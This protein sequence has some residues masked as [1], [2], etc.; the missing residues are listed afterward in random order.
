MYINTLLFFSVVESQGQ[1]EGNLEHSKILSTLLLLSPVHT[2]FSNICTDVYIIK[3]EVTLSISRSMGSH[4]RC[5]VL[6]YSS[7]KIALNGLVN[8]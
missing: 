7:K 4:S 6:G 1:D 8:G 3:F 5:H 2:T